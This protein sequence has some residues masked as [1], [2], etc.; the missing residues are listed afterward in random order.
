[1]RRKIGIIAFT[2]IVILS[3]HSLGLAD[4]AI[5]NI[6][7]EL[8]HQTSVVITGQS[9]GTK[10]PA[11]P[12]LW[13]DGTSDPPLS[14]HYDAWL[15][16]NAQEGSHYNMT[17][18]EV[19]FREV[20]A[21]HSRI[22]YILG[23]AHALHDQAGSY[24]IGGNVGIG[25]NIQS[26]EFFIMYWYRLDPAFDEE[27]HPIYGDNMKEIVLTNTEGSYYPDGWGAFG[28]ASWCGND[29]PDVNQTGPIKLGRIPINPENQ[30]APYACSGNNLV[31]HNN[32]IIGWI[33]MQWEGT[34]NH[35][36]DGPQISFTTYPDGQRTYRSHYGDG[37]TVSE[38]TRGPWANYPKEND[39]RFIGLGGFGR[40]PRENNGV[41]SFRYF[42]GVYMDNTHARVM[43]GDSPNYDNCHKM[44]PQIPSE[45]SNES[46]TIG[47]NLGNFN[48]NETGY[49]FVFDADNNHNSTG[50]PVTIGGGGGGIPP[51]IPQN[52]F[53]EQ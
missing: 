52:L 43:L 9:F 41:N 24:A 1:M 29:T 28:Y 5:V 7:G 18:R 17:Y 12:L 37:I 45:W 25:K 21:P 11:H 31:Y 22:N 36:Y 30:N 4:P 19:P 10:N 40:V 26:H 23:G 2:I 6:S 20:D 32:P 49:V 16:N 51:S 47:V 48:N 13:D 3:I 50:Y 14:T 8:S 33:K 53:I 42:A 35:Q 34:Y 15:P 46:I 27:N 44:E 39:L 38:Y